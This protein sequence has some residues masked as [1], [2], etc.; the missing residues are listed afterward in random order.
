MRC[1]HDWELEQ[2]IDGLL[3]AGQCRRCS[4][5]WFVSEI[6][7]IG[8]GVAFTT[9]Y[10]AADGGDADDRTRHEVEGLLNAS[11]R[12]FLARRRAVQWVP[13][14]PRPWSRRVV[15]RCRGAGRP[16]RG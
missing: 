7:P 9:M 13:G 10:R 5:A 2:E 15:G 3:M 14:R 16:R 8:G 6:R 4:V 1:E 12:A 11:V